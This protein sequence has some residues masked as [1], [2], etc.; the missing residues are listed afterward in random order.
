MYW[1]VYVAALIYAATVVIAI[2]MA[3]RVKGGEENGG[4]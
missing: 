1:G 2:Y 4:E 3:S